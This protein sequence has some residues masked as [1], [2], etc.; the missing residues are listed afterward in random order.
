[1]LAQAPPIG[2]IPVTDFSIAETFYSGTLGLPLAS[3]DSFA[4]VLKAASNVML[5][6]VL[7]DPAF[8]PQPFTIFGWEHPN[9][10]AASR[11]L[12]AAGVTPLRFPS[13]EQDEH[14]IWTAPNGD[15]VL[16]FRDPFGN[17][18]SLSTHLPVRPE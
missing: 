16:W 14:A 3:R 7:V 9:L 8:T 17:T 6:C 4:L 10:T 18:L 5:R 1:M 15:R 11:T 12:S 13:F 2:F